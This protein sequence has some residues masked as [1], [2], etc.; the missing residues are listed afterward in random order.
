M[1]LAALDHGASKVI[2]VDRTAKYLRVA[3][4]RIEEGRFPMIASKKRYKFHPACLAFPL[5][6]E[7]E[8]RELAE[9]IKFRGLLHPVITWKGQ[10]LDGRNRLAAC[11]RAG[12][13]PRFMEWEAAAL[14]SSW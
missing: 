13:E 12:V 10:I 11:E 8:L 1:L 6:P 2:G 3:R 5:L 14:P 4:K 7:S 9:D